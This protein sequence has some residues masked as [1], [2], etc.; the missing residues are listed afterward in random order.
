M[1][2]P[3]KAVEEPLRPFLDAAEVRA[4]SLPEVHKGGVDPVSAGILLERCAITLEAYEIAFE[5]MQ[6]ERTTL[7]SHSDRAQSESSEPP[8]AIAARTLE[9]AARTVDTMLAEAEAEAAQI[10]EA[11]AGEHQKL[12][13]TLER[14]KQDHAAA[15]ESLR[16]ALSV[17]AAK[18]EADLEAARQ[19]H[20]AAMKA[21]RATLSVEATEAETELNKVREQVVQWRSDI[22]ARAETA[23][24]AL[25]GVLAAA[26]EVFAATQSNLARPVGDNARPPSAPAP[27]EAAP[28]SAAD[29]DFVDVPS[30]VLGASAPEPTAPAHPA[31][32]PPRQRR[33]R[34]P[35]D[36]AAP[37]ETSIPPEAAPSG[38][39]PRTPLEIFQ[40]PQQ[41]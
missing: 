37:V 26:N 34:P 12:N 18:S 32:K 28:G 8:S 13:E 24:T 16:T 14:A 30:F 17:E 27:R 15:A 35:K 31:P 23:A 33:Q 1:N 2:N 10:R 7:L 19:A 29:S 3:A 5:N 20:A 25:A 38:Q 11:F 36:S 41:P 9:A 4:Q 39:A 6:Q 40:N 22:K 21:L